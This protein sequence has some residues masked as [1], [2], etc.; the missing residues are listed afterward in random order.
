MVS[1]AKMAIVH[2][3]ERPVAIAVGGFSICVMRSDA[4][5]DHLVFA[6]V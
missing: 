3:P 1:L 4:T 2:T 6:E 5:A